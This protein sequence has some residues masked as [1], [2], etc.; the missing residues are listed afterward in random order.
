MK[1]NKKK[2]IK[3]KTSLE[4]VNYPKKKILELVETFGLDVDLDRWD[5]K[6]KGF[7][8]INFF[9]LKEAGCVIIHK[10]DLDVNIHHEKEYIEESFRGFLLKAGEAQFKNKLKSLLEI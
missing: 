4:G 6:D 1:D 7:M 10:D 2:M 8:R 5:E 3:K 9:A